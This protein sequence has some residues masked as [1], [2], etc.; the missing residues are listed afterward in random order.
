MLMSHLQISA[1]VAQTRQTPNFRT[2]P[3]CQTSNLT[4]SC[5][6][7]TFVLRY[8]NSLG[9]LPDFSDTLIEYAYER[10]TVCHPSLYAYYFECLQVITEQR[11]SEQL[12]IK[13]A[14]LTSED[15]FSRRDIFV[16]FRY[17]GISVDDAS[18]LTDGQIRDKFQA[19][20]SDLGAAAQQQ[21]R[22]HLYKIGRFRNSTIL[23][24]ASRQSVDTYE[25]ALSWLGNG[26]DKSTSDDA[27][28][29]VYGFKAR[30]SSVLLLCFADFFTE[31]REQGERRHSPESA[32][33]DRKS[34]EE[35]HAQQLPPY[36]GARDY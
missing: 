21:A 36:W 11:H 12:Q 18:N 1:R 2:S 23:I 33:D 6:T 5:D 20:Q 29:A 26:V 27:L 17:I 28:L 13:L 3:A 35:Q 19:Q 14:T 32:R 16:A 9:I 10:Q 7:L 30:A 24:N 15:V 8:Y 4:S 31:R 22:D 25:D 34:P